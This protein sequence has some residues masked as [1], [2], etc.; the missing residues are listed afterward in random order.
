[1]TFLIN[2]TRYKT[3]L[4]KV[5]DDYEKQAYSSHASRKGAFD[6]TWKYIISQITHKKEEQKLSF[7]IVIYNEENLNEVNM[8]DMLMRRK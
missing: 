4:S 3:I 2:N 1:M 7:Y 6:P 8:W 5:K